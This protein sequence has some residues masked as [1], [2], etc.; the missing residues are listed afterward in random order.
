[1]PTTTTYQ[2]IGMTCG[3][4]ANAVTEELS[5]LPGVR[6]VHVDLGTGTATVTSDAVLP[7]DEV[8]NA[9]DEA[10]YQLAGIDG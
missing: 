8:R 7:V 1:M 10:G 9:V 6:E 4:C 5:V 3:H 2:I